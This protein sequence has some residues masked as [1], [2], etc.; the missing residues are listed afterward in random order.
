MLDRRSAYYLLATKED[1]AAIGWRRPC[2]YDLPGRSDKCDT[3]P[4][5]KRTPR[6]TS[7]VTFRNEPAVV[8]IRAAGPREGER[9]REIAHASKAYWGYDAQLVRHWA[10]SLDLSPDRLRQ[11]HVHVAE[12]QA[13]VV[14]W[15]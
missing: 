14:A 8:L 9:L 5:T 4:G 11:H 1:N 12:A 2:A 7:H 6:R 10:S 13:R 15:L 3:L